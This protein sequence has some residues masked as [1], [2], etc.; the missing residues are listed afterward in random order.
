MFK[1]N[2]SNYFISVKH[3]CSFLNFNNL[4]N[5]LDVIPQENDVVVDFSLC[6]FVDHTALENIDSY[7]ELFYKKGGN[8]EVIGL[9]MLGTRSEACSAAQR[10]DQQRGY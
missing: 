10:F 3:F 9:D 8:L 4:K 7:Q 1:E 2:D 6:A 5:K